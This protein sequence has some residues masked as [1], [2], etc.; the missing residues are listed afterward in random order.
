MFFGSLS[1]PDVLE[2]SFPTLLAV[3]WLAILPNCRMAANSCATGCISGNVVASRTVIT[4]D[5]PAWTFLVSL[6]L[7]RGLVVAV[8][9]TDLVGG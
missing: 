7:I 6:G 9:G 4:D 2:P 1:D 5:C 3:F 8:A